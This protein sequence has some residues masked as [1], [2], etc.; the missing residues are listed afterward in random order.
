MTTELAHKELLLPTTNYM[1]L[2]MGPSHPAM[3]GIIRINLTLDG[4]RIV[5]A[6]VDIGFLH[7]AF[8][9]MVERHTWNQ[10]IVYTDRLNYVSAMINNVG[11]CLAV[12][13]LLDIE[14]PP[15]GVF[16]RVIMSEVSRV[17]DHLTCV[18]A[19]VMETGALTAFL[20]PMKAREY[21]YEIVEMCCGAR[22]TTNW[23]RIGGISADVPDN[24]SDAI[25]DRLPK[26][27][28]VISEVDKLVT[29]NRIFIDRYQNVGSMSK[30][31]AITWGFTGPCLRAAGVPFDVRR[32][33]PY[34]NYDQFDFEIP[35]GTRG[36]VFDRYL[37]RMFEME[38]SLQIIEQALDKLPDGP[39]SV[40]DKTITLPEK[41][42][43]YGNIEGLMNQFKLIMEGHGI[44]P[45][46]G[47]VY[48]AVEAANGELGF[49]V[50]STGEDTPYKCRC[51]PP[52]FGLTA[53][54][55][56]MI[57]GQMVADVVP[58]FG[59]INMIGGELDR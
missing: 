13:K 23:T 12:E 33:Q 20:Y 53:A 49:Y 8:E 21:L 56:K 52:C 30:E 27:R 43:V 11:Y 59:S 48:H 16:L 25:L 14:L 10:G 15:R 2:A 32:D 19:Q 57:I 34:L 47:E 41:T 38:Q 55:P 7:R 4:E 35:V 24:F 45:P 3:H 37:V 42:D 29:R 22:I 1:T 26:V 6:T 18:A 9:K 17:I 5:D 40:E 50:I 31:D 36:D 58:I 28:D 39:V 51:R 44:K 46:P 54:I